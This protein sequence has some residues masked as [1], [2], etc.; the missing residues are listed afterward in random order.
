M[1]CFRNDITTLAL[2]GHGSETIIFFSMG[3]GEVIHFLVI[4]FSLRYF[5]TKFDLLMFSII[6]DIIST[7]TV[8]LKVYFLLF[9]QY[10]N[11]KMAACV[12]MKYSPKTHFK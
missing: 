5:A 2:Y 7:F 6:F 4:I 10:N 9:Y 1:V 11:N 3:H 12:N 8:E